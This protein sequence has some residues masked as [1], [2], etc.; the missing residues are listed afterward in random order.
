MF[1][2]FSSLRWLLLGSVVC[3]AQS[4]LAADYTDPLGVNQALGF[5]TK[6]PAANVGAPTLPP[7]LANA[8][9]EIRP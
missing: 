8:P 9:A 6:P 1:H 3:I 7:Q 2:R 5:T 4:A